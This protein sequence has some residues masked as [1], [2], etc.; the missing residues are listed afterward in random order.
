MATPTPPAPPVGPDTLVTI[1]ILQNESINRRVKIPLRDLGARV[2]PQKIRQILAIPPHFTLS[3][4]RYSD[5]AA[6]Y[7]QLDSENP[8][9]YKQ[10]YRAAKAKLKLRIKVTSSPTTPSAEAPAASIP[11]P[12]SQKEQASQRHSYLDTVLS[13]PLSN[14]MPQDT[15]ASRSHGVSPPPLS[16]KPPQSAYALRFSKDDTANGSFCIDCNHCGRVIS[17]DHYHCAICDDGDYDLCLDCVEAGVTCSGDDHWLLKRLVQNGLIKNSTTETLAPKRVQEPSVHKPSNDL[18]KPGYS[19]TLAKQAA[20]IIAQALHVGDERTCDACFREFPEA[21]MVTCNTCEDYDLC[22]ACLLK[23]THSHGHSFS[24][25]QGGELPSNNLPAGPVRHR[26][27]CDGC[28]KRIIGERHKCLACPDFDY[29]SSCIKAAHQTHPGHGFVPVYMPLPSSIQPQELHHNIYCD[30]PLCRNKPSATCIIGVRYKCA[31]CHDTDF[32]QSCEAL[33]TNPHN[34]THPLIKFQTGVRNVSVSTLGDDG[35]GGSQVVMGDRSA[36]VLPP[37]ST[38]VNQTS[39]TQTTNEGEP[40]NE[41]AEEAEKPEANHQTAASVEQPE[42]VTTEEHSAYFTR[43]TVPDGT[44]IAPSHVFEQTWTLYNPGP[45]SWPVGTSVGYVGGDVMFNIDSDHPSSTQALRSA[46]SSNELT[47]PVGPSESANFTVTLKSPQQTG[48][49]IS[50]WRLKLQD[51]TPFGHKLWCDI[52]VVEEPQVVEDPVEE[53]AQIESETALTES[54]MIFPKLEKESPISSTH[55]AISTAPP[56]PPLSSSDERDILEDIESLKLEDVDTE[57]EPGFLTDDE[58]DILDASDQ[59]CLN[60][61]H[62]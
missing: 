29:C 57:D 26:A 62:A 53:P 42:P 59:E 40:N 56:A 58:Y 31:I 46:M 38:A 11:E 44:P 2:F 15:E 4:E 9:I 14:T 13:S 49:A 21:K 25:I 8:A 5:S 17:T 33:P 45:L 50:Y 10:L 41:K 28:D 16:V 35:F 19:K 47:H 20:N 12:P 55:E 43:D 39:A 34:R 23:N 52:K 24:A 27:L 48:T 18:Q 6:S 30:G 61:K 37:T 36:P 7:V 1:K 51:G 3:L 32:C 22:F 60:G 54:N